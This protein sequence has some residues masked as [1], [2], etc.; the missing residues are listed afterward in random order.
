MRIEVDDGGWRMEDAA[1]AASDG[2]EL[3]MMQT[4]QSMQ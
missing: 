1:A 4:M 2:I 3:Q